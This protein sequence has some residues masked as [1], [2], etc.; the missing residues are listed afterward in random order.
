MVRRLSPSRR[1]RRAPGARRGLAPLEFVAALP[2]ILLLGALMM[3]VGGIGLI[4]SRAQIYARYH[5]WRSGSIRTA[6][7]PAPRLWSGRATLTVPGAGDLLEPDRVWNLGNLRE[8]ILRGP[9]I[10]GARVDGLL[11]IGADVH[12]ANARYRQEVPMLYPVTG[13]RT[14]DGN[15][16]QQML[17]NPWEFHE[18]PFSL[19]ENQPDAYR[20]SGSDHLVELRSRARVWYDF[21]EDSIE[22]AMEPPREALLAMPGNADLDP[23]DRD[24]ELIA[25]YGNPPRNFHPRFLQ[26]G[27]RGIATWSGSVLATAND[28]PFQVLRDNVRRVPGR[29]ASTFINMY[30]Q[31]LAEA[32]NR[33]DQ[34]QAAMPPDQAAIAAVEQE[35]AEIEAKLNPMVEFRNRLPQRNR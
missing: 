8:P 1:T 24:D 16:T 6:S 14:F 12:S 13:R 34:L 17:A 4:M 23:L 18:S 31:Q 11:E 25:E 27:G 29:M 33:L 32:Q 20:R 5:Q 22:D 9:A 10:A 26:P 3:V 19:G 30:R 15:V 28:R 7:D 35:I 21:Q 2:F